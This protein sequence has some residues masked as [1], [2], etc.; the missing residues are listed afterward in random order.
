M[1]YLFNLNIFL[2][3]FIN[4]YIYLVS[5]TSLP[6]NQPT[7]EPSSPSGQPTSLPTSVPSCGLGSN[8]SPSLCSPC[9]PGTYRNDLDEQ[10]KECPKGYFN[11]IAGATSC[12]ICEYPSYNKAGSSSCQEVFINL[13]YNIAAIMFTF[14]FSVAFIFS[15]IYGGKH[16]Y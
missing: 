8:G 3:L 15:M 1:T 10:C 13:D 7:S 4:Q 12:D 11:N 14:I 6:T 5:P 9:E 2:F 16:R